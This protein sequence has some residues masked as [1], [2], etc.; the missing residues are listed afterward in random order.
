VNRRL[1]AL[2]GPA[3][4]DPG[5]DA[6]VIISRA[7]VPASKLATISEWEDTTLGADLGV[8]GASTDEVYAA[9]DHLLTRQGCHWSR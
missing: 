5:P 9:L 1:P 7:V 3:G 4:P 2:S 6:G 8:A